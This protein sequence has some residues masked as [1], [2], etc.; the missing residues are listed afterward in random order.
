MIRTLISK[1]PLALSF[2][3]LGLTWLVSLLVWAQ[4]TSNAFES[5]SAY[6]FFP[7]LGL[8]AF[9]ALWTSYVVGAGTLHLGIEKKKVSLFHKINASAIILLILLHPGILINQLYLDG[10]GVPPASYAEYVS[11][12][13]IWV[14]YLG[15]VS[16]LIFLAFELRHW[17]AKKNWWKWVLYAND[18]AMFFIFYHGLTLG[19]ELQSSWFQ[20]VWWFYG[21]TLVVAIAYLRYFSKRT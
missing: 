2:S 11:A 5:P 20:F 1:Y 18:A 17:F 9:S 14:V 13:Y 16:M 4:S 21:A 15:V 7:L 8:L 12:N 19:A 3:L 6:D 10:F